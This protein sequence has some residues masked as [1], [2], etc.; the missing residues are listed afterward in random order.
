MA[1]RHNNFNMLRL[2]FASMVIL[3]HVPD[4]QDGHRQ[5]ELLTQVFG[6]LSFGELAVDSFFV[7]SGYLVSKSWMARPV[8]RAYLAARLLR[9]F[10]GFAVASLICALVVGPMYGGAEYLEQ[11]N[12]LRYAWTWI[13]LAPPST[14]PV[15]A[16]TPY[17]LLNASLWTIR[18]EFFCYLLVMALGLLL[19]L[20]QARV[21]AALAVVLV[22]AFVS[23]RMGGW[24]PPSPM[25][26]NLVRC[27]MVFSAGACF[28]WFE[29]GWVWSGTRAAVALLMWLLLMPLN[30]LAEVATA[31]CWGYAILVF[32]K[33]GLGPLA[34]HRLPDMSYGT[35][36]YAW[37][38]NKIL[39]WHWPDM[40]LVWGVTLTMALSMAAG[41]LSW[42]FVERPALR[43]KQRGLT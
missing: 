29:S 24:T 31:W 20:Q 13:T 2:V 26:E 1:E 38:I 17:P 6:T 3:S 21:W 39:L 18:Y 16:G 40:P 19:P 25:V 12:G 36:L 10:P 14:P 37:P 23:L 28:A 35:Y 4:L 5:R 8:A 11:F 30:P 32:A 7:L 9:I 33:Q 43:L 22:V 15:F 27:A 34:F 42:R 41:A